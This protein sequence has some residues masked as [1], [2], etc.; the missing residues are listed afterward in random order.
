MTGDLIGLGASALLWVAGQLST[1]RAQAHAIRTAPRSWLEHPEVGPS[2]RAAASWGLR[3]AWP[4]T[5][6]LLPR[7]AG[8]I[9][10]FAVLEAMG[11]ILAVELFACVLFAGSWTLRLR[12]A[13]RVERDEYVEREGL[14]PAPRRPWLF[15]WYWGSTGAACLAFAAV[16]CFA[17]R[18]VVEL[19]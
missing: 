2:Y 18:A 3:D 11:V 5:V 15:A 12:D 16:A 17:G 13:A 8:L 9:V 10:G 7:L 1:L 14:E 4:A 6:A 19:L